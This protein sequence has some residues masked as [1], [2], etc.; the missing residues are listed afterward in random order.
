MLFKIVTKE[1]FRSLVDQLLA[2]NEVIGPRRVGVRRNGKPEHQFLPIERFEDM[3]L[4]YEKTAFSA[5]TYFLPFR[6]SLSRTRF[7]NGDW[8]QEISYRVQ[9]R[10][11][12]GSQRAGGAQRMDARAP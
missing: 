1:G 2:S 3:D 11:L 4:D 12:V 9:P 8:Q 7:K 10:A 5:K 6:E